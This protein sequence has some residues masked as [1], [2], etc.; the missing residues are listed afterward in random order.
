MDLIYIILSICVVIVLILITYMNRVKRTN[1]FTEIFKRL[2]LKYPTVSSF[3]LGYDVDKKAYKN[4]YLD[5]G[6]SKKTKQSIGTVIRYETYPVNLESMYILLNTNHGN[7]K[8]NTTNGS[9]GGGGF[10]I[11]GM[12]TAKFDCPNDE[13]Y[14]GVNCVLKPLCTSPVDDDTYKLLKISQFDQLNLYNNMFSYTKPDPTYYKTDDTND[15]QYH[16]KLKIYCKPNNEYSIES[17]ADNELLDFNTKLCKPYDICQDKL[18]GFRHNYK[19]DAHDEPLL[20]NSYYICQNNKSVEIACGANLVYSDSNKGCISKSECLNKGNATLYMDNTRYIQ[21]NNDIGVIVDCEYRQRVRQ[22]HNNR[23][24]M[25]SHDYIINVKSD[26][27]YIDIDDETG[28]ISCKI[29]SC[30]PYELIYDD[31]II[32]YTYATTKCVTNEEN[33]EETEEIYKCDNSANSTDPEGEYEYEWGEKFTYK[34]PNWPKEIL[35]TKTMKCVAPKKSD[36]ISNT[37]IVD[38]QWSSAMFNQHPFNLGTQKYMC[39]SSEFQVDYI[40]NTITPNLPALFPNYAI[41]VKKPCSTASELMTRKDFNYI[42]YYPLGPKSD[43]IPLLY[44]TPLAD[45]TLD[46]SYPYYDVLRKKYILSYLYWSEDHK[47]MRAT[48]VDDNPPL[49]F[50]PIDQNSAVAKDNKIKLIMVGW[51]G[52]YLTY[53][54][55]TLE[56]K[57]YMINVDG[58]GLTHFVE[59]PTAVPSVKDEFRPTLH[60]I[61]LRVK[62]ENFAF[63]IPF[64][65]IPDGVTVDMTPG[66]VSPNTFTITNQGMYFGTK[67]ME[68]GYMFLYLTILIPTDTTK[69]EVKYRFNTDTTISVTIDYSKIQ[70]IV[71]GTQPTISSNE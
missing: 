69:R 47:L 26:S 30:E 22:R 37:S 20:E 68:T 36:L 31:N 9:S 33:D 57:L 34:I 24:R 43:D 53:D 71:I 29:K 42:R 39:D 21:C 66:G 56:S 11:D 12:T 4:V 70:K 52:L 48:F 32:K 10:T 61:D 3:T 58:Y 41:N 49:N 14:E 45:G 15:S 60:E 18:N 1:D 16:Q 2:S 65:S 23:R 19:I 38:L 44:T 64:I 67:F 50:L 59:S 27:D 8:P 17:C 5:G 7:I 25:K 46:G 13:V 35:D 63:Q 55:P 28:V 6:T 54:W 62:V 40:K 51:P